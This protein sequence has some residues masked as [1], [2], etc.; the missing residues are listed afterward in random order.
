MRNM[1]SEHV[2]GKMVELSQFSE[3]CARLDQ[4]IGILD[5]RGEHSQN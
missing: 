4:E 3:D 5:S 1:Y 2:P